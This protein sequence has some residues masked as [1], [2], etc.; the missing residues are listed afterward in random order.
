MS[1]IDVFIGILI[2]LMN[3]TILRL[4]TEF[5]GYPLS[6]FDATFTNAGTNLVQAYSGISFFVPMTLLFSL[7]ALVIGAELGL[8]TIKGI[9]YIVATIR[10]SG[11]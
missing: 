4:P 6:T 8:V 2:W 3:N 7:V 11:T 5:S 9:K 10:G 1:V